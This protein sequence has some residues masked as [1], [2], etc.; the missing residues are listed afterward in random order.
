MNML[1]DV[2]VQNEKIIYKGVPSKKCF[3][4]ESIFNPM[5]VV[6]IILAVF[7]F[8]VFYT[9]NNN[10]I[11]LF[12]LND[13]TIIL[14]VHLLPVYIYIIGIFLTYKKFDNMEFVITSK[15]IYVSKGTIFKTYDKASFKD[16]VGTKVYKGFFDKL[17]NTGDVVIAIDNN[18]TNNHSFI[19][20]EDLDNYDEICSIINR[21]SYKH[22]NKF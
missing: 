13:I 3:V 20:I 2:V 12:E 6:S 19:V 11:K 17:T 18:Y 21:F 9:L 1:K 14:L 10:N 8:L 5:L 15:G 22:N 4:L 16:I 7:D